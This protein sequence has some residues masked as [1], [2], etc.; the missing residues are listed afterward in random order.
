MLHCLGD[1]DK[2]KRPYMF[3][4]NITIAAR[5]HSTCQQRLNVFLS[6]YF[7]A[8]LVE[9]CRSGGPTVM[10][11]I[12]HSLLPQTMSTPPSPL[13]PNRSF[14]RSLFPFWLPNRMSCL[15]SPK[16]FAINAAESSPSPLKFS[17]LPLVSAARPPSEF[18][19]TSDCSSSG[20]VSAF[21]AFK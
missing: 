13:Y 21:P 6:D 16:A 9:F 17:S 2:N 20:I 14:L 15:D 4:T 11:F 10:V 3:S 5:L 18:P 1:N 12:S 19:P 8:T 7:P